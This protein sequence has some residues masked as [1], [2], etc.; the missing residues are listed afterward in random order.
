[1]KRSKVVLPYVVPE[2]QDTPGSRAMRA[3]IVYQERKKDRGFRLE[4]KKR[5]D[6][7]ISWG[8]P[9]FLETYEHLHRHRDA[10]VVKERVE[11]CRESLAARALSRRGRRRLR[12]RYAG[13]LADSTEEEVTGFFPIK[14]EYC[15]AT[16][17]AHKL[18]GRSYV[19][20]GDVYLMISPVPLEVTSTGAVIGASA[21]A[22]K[23]KRCTYSCGA[24]FRV[25]NTDGHT[26][27]DL[28]GRAMQHATLL[29]TS[30][31]L[32][33]QRGAKKVAMKKLPRLH[34]IDDTPSAG[35]MY[36]AVPDP[37]KPSPKQ[38]QLRDTGSTCGFDA[39][40]M[41]W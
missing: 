15:V 26:A 10:K 6:I 24:A 4:E 35:L 2:F 19:L 9:N 41:D 22:G 17:R 14:D 5:S 27:V 18:Q 20:V 28:K 37:A 16:R 13:V 40:F 30:H 34:K 21:H 36:P 3:A 38:P 33:A 1:M 8:I 29:D 25:A 12:P 7:T 39:F 32:L 11:A 31:F 23:D